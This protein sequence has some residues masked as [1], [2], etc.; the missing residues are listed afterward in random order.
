MQFFQLIVTSEIVK[1]RINFVYNLFLLTVIRLK[2]VIIITVITVGQ[3]YDY[4]HKFDTK[5]LL[6]DSLF[7][8][9]GIIKSNCFSFFVLFVTFL[10]AHCYNI[11]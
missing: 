5:L 6:D 7:V 9:V 4:V 2:I 1:S 3:D 10:I 11:S 8:T